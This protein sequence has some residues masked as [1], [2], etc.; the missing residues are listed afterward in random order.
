MKEN[1]VSFT[2]EE[3]SAK[4]KEMRKEEAAAYYQRN[5]EKILQ[6]NKDYRRRKAIAA[7]TAE[8]CVK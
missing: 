5:R 4:I 7:L 6:R 8:R 3:I 2:E 1:K